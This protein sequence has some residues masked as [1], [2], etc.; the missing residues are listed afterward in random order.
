MAA[1]KELTVEEKLKA[2]YE[3]QKIDSEIDRIQVLKGELPIEVQDLEDELS[4]LQTRIE[5]IKD[6]VKETETYIE[7]KKLSIKESESLIKKYNKQLDS[8]KN[9]REYEALTK[10]IEL[11]KLEIQ[12][13]E[14]RIREAHEQIKQKNEYLDQTK[15]AVTAKKKELEA[16]KEELE[17]IVAETEKE[18]KDLLKKSK[19]AQGEIDE[20]LLSAYNKIRSSYKNGL[21]VVKIDRDSCGGCYSKIPAQRQYEIAQRKKVIV[22]ENCGRILVDAAIDVE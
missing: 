11:Q 6:E 4:G 9:N 20:R 18:E 15:K 16:K 21:A 5:K 13:C 10:E 19:K 3:L 8:V 22:C 12:L 14:K 17:K 1:V 7:E 2:L